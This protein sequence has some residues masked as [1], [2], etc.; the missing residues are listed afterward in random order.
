MI[1][2]LGEILFSDEKR[3]VVLTG[4]SYSMRNPVLKVR[5]FI[6]SVEV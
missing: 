2:I 1:Y 6:L 4:D 3:S 5:E